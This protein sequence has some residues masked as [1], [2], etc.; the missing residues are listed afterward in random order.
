MITY[1]EP[2]SYTDQPATDDETSI[3]PAAGASSVPANLAHLLDL[4]WC[5]GFYDGDGCGTIS[6][7]QLP[8]RK[9][10]TYRLR[11]QVVQNCYNTLR[12]FQSVVDESCC[13]TKVTRRMDHNRQVYV[14]AYEGRHALAALIKLEPY[15]IRKRIEAQAVFQFWA[16]ARMG[17]YSG[18]NGFPLEV[19]EEREYWYRKLQARAV[20]RHAPAARAEHGKQSHQ[21]SP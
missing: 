6:K 16:L 5:A 10:P 11:L 17:T 9:H 3:S 19:W 1:E 13:F 2:S 20:R 8:G 14:L 7:Q 15:L 4:S 12:H 21:V 18:P